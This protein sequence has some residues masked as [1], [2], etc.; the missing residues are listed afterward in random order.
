MADERE[1]QARKAVLQHMLD[2]ED[3]FERFLLDPDT[4]LA[5]FPDLHMRDV[6]MIK[7]KVKD[8]SSLERFAHLVINT[9]IRSE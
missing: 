4:T 7:R 1:R 5:E 3:Y 2:D 8:R 9:Q 6:R